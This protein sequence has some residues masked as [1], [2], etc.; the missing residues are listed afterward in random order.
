MTFKPATLTAISKF[1]DYPN[2]AQF[3]KDWAHLSDEA[4]NQLK[5]GLGFGTLTY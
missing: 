3:R 2:I 1:F 5:E 4:K